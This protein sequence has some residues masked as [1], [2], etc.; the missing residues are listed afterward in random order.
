[1]TS[2][3]DV[4][5]TSGSDVDIHSIVHKAGAE[6][7]PHPVQS[8]DHCEHVVKTALIGYP[9]LAAD[10]VIN[11][12]MR[13]K[14]VETM[15]NVIRQLNLEFMKS[16]F[17]EGDSPE[18]MVRKT[19][20]RQR[21]YE[22][23]IE[24]AVNLAGIERRVV[25]FSDD[26]S[27]QSFKHIAETLSAWETVE[28][29]ES[30]TG[31]ENPVATSV[32]EKLLGDMR[33]VMSGAG[34]V[35]KMGEEIKTGL[36]Q[37][38]LASSFIAAAEK[39]LQ[40][41]IYYQMVTRGLCKFGNDYAIGLRWLRHLGYV[42]VSTNPVLAARAYDDDPSLWEGL[43]TIAKEHQE[44]FK[45]PECFK[46]EIAMEATKSALWPNLTVYRPIALLSK[47][48]DGLVSYQLNPNVAASLEG[49]MEDALKIYT[50][51]QEFL[52]GYDAHLTWGYSKMEEMSRPN[53]VF[54]V[55]GG[56]PAA[57]EVTTA[58]NSMGIGTNNTVTYTVAQETT[59]I[60]AAMKGMAHALKMGIPVTQAYETN[61]GGR[62]ESHLREL[63]AERLLREAL[64]RVG[65]VEATLRKLAE[66]IG[67]V[68]ELSKAS[69]LEDGIRLV[70]SFKYL[71]SL[72]TPAFAEA[73]AE[74]R[75]HGDSKEENAAF[76]ARLESDIGYAGTLVAQRVYRIFFTPENRLRWMAY[77]HRAYG[78]ALDKVG[79]VMD[80][81]DVLPASKRKPS[82]TYLTLARRNMTNTE[83]PDHQMKVLDTSRRPG[84]NLTDFEDAVTKEHDLGILQRLMKLGDFR[85]AYE[86]TPELAERMRDAGVEGDFGV[87]GLKVEDWPT[88]GSV[89]KT[90]TEFTNA[91][92][93]FREKAVK[94]VQ[95]VA[96]NMV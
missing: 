36:T 76:L 47:L 26:E 33:K 8:L 27:A 77:L 56:S 6:K 19:Q 49:S 9:Q 81:I 31:S 40:G 11:R 30:V 89:V 83:F 37:G 71:K 45:D 93:R 65:D 58:F 48:H 95:D 60:L 86:L 69:S 62:L 50:S 59:L 85:R 5:S 10:H 28:R 88:F 87:G 53:I 7:L 63:E 54:K 67:A 44:W 14:L 4:S 74:A 57:V 18:V 41:N 12:E 13:G 96:K 61:M 16:R 32:V 15:G 17:T 3:K 25:G 64:G 24:A 46:D 43:R 66:A 79:E 39:V 82:D 73:V 55:A 22:V 68:E 1:M 42:Q 35:A 20:V 29:R 51:A 92:N 70:C 91:Y 23:L 34:M 38:K 80:K 72:S 94:V 90:M 84:F 78:L 2:G 75:V 52:R 21:A